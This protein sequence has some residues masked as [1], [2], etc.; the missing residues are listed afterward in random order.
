[1]KYGKWIPLTFVVLSNAVLAGDL[2]VVGDVTHS[3]DS[4]SRSTFDG[5]LTSAGA[6]GLSS[7]DSGNGN[8]WRVQLGYGFNS[9]LAIE[10]GYIDFGKAKYSAAYAGGAATGELKAGGV[11][12]VALGI[13]P[14]SDNFAIFGKAGAVAL[15]AKSSLAAS[16]PASAATDNATSSEVR[17]LVGLGASY[18]LVDNVDLRA[19]FDHVNGIGKS[20]KTGTMDS[21]MF[22]LGVAYHF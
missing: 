12:L 5:A 4:L 2:Y 14:L 20:N 22:S 7:S 10:A 1:M 18:K 11:D 16:A 13:L 8:Q 15:K 3:K 17:P 6:T 21:N 19:E 9:N